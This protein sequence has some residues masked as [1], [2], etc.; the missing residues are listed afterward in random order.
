MHGFNVPHMPQAAHALLRLRKK[1][2]RAALAVLT[3]GKNSMTE[4]IRL[5]LN[6]KFYD[7]P[8]GKQSICFHDYRIVFGWLDNK[9][10]YVT[11]KSKDIESIYP[12]ITIE[13]KDGTDALD[14]MNWIGSHNKYQIPFAMKIIELSAFLGECL[15]IQECE[16]E[17]ETPLEKFEAALEGKPANIK[18][19][20]AIKR[21]MWWLQRHPYMSNISNAPMPPDTTSLDM[22]NEYFG[23]K[24]KCE[25]PKDPRWRPKNHAEVEK[26]IKWL[27]GELLSCSNFGKTPKDIKEAINK[28]FEI[29]KCESSPE[30]IPTRTTPKPYDFGTIKDFVDWVNSKRGGGEFPIGLYMIYKYFGIKES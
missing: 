19:L 18:D 22:I 12:R 13:I 29:E 3:K 25:E 9:K 7:V 17:P 8:I 27:Q 15:N 2:T 4:T 5:P 16:Y 30:K 21:F 11:N 14:E 28:Y 20:E 24:E 26:F 23:I 10:A 6:G 1:E